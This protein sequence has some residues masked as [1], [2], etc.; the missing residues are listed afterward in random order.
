MCEW[1]T[2]ARSPTA[3]G[4]SGTADRQ[5]VQSAV[6]VAGTGELEV[7]RRDGGDEARVEGFGDPQRRVDA[8][9]AGAKRQLVNPE[10]SRVKDAEDLHGREVRLE[11]L[12]VL[13][14]R[15]LAQVPRVLRLLRARRRQG[16]P[17]GRGDVGDRG[18]A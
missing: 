9:P 2:I 1:S 7:A 5:E 12:P 11:Q 8:I 16:Q 17:V 4:R 10:L 6:E 14:H 15:V 3:S 13:A 18:E